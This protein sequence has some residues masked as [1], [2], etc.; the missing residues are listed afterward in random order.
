MLGVA[1]LE[2]VQANGTG[3][4]GDRLGRLGADLEAILG[5]LR[6]PTTDSAGETV[7]STDDVPLVRVRDLAPRRFGVQLPPDADRPGPYVARDVD[8]ELERLLNARSP[9][10]TVIAP[11]LSGAIRAVF[12]ALRRVL[13]DDHVLLVHEL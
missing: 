6:S 7:S 9:V 13:P 10:V 2:D 4:L 5:A 8:D 11:P 12:E 1:V 3:L